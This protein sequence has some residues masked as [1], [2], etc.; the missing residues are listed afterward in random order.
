MSLSEIKM[1]PG[2]PHFELQTTL[3]GKPFSLDFKFSARSQSFT[4][5]LYDSIGLLCTFAAAP[6]VDLLEPYRYSERSPQGILFF[7]S[8]PTSDLS[9]PDLSELGTRVTLMYA[10]PE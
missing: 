3:D 10:E 1:K 7:Y 2:T 5:N 6:M 9:P 4:V 8:T